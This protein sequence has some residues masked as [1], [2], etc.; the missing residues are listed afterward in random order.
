MVSSRQLTQKS[1][2]RRLDWPLIALI[3]ILCIISV[4]TIHSAMGGGQ[5]SLDFGVRQIFYYILGAIIA[6]MIMLFSPKKIRNYTYTVYI[7]FNILLFGLILLPESSITPVINGAKSW[8]RFGPIS[9]QPSEFMKIVLILVISKV[10]AQH[11][12]FTFNKSFQTDVMLLLKIAGVSFVPIALILLQND[13][14]TTLVFLAIIAGIVIVSGV[15][16][17]ILAPLFGSAIV[18]GGSLI[19]SI[20]YKPRLIE[21]VAGIKTY[22]LGRINSWL[23]PYAYSSGDGFHLTESLKAIGSGQLIGKGLNNGEVYIPENHT[24]FIFSVI[25]EEF[26]FLGSVILLGIFLLLLLH[27]I[28]MAMNS[29]DLFNKSFIIGFISLLLF[30]IFQNI[31]MTIQLLPITGIPLPFISYGGSSL[32]SLMSGVG[33]LLS[34]HYHTPKKYNDEATTQKRTTS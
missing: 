26:G 1:F 29:D 28:R 17:K 32:W 4:T 15:T 21:N 24:D 3:I 8:Y 2:L 7:I 11:N 10:V 20:I 12:R 14:G 27:L 19:L 23:D 9:I 18:L 16:W 6:F 25:G 13:L 33:V 34:I 5:Y 30:H 31:G 22:Q